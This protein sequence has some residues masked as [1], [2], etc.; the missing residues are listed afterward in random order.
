MT[1]VIGV[2]WATERKNRALVAL[3]I[4]KVGEWR[5]AHVQPAVEDETVVRACTDLGNAVVAVDTPFGWPRNFV[6]FVAGWRPT[7]ASAAPPEPDL[8]RL[9]R[10]DRV[11]RAEVP[12]EP[13]SVSAD[14]IAMGARCWAGILASQRLWAQV[15]LDGNRRG[16]GP[17]IVEVYPGAT[18]VALGRTRAVA[19]DEDSYK[20]DS[21][22]RRRVVRH[23]ASLL[24]VD[25]STHEDEIVSDGNDS[26]RTD[27]F[28]A[29]ITAGL[30]Q[31]CK[32]HG[33]A[34]RG[35]RVRHPTLSELEDAR[36][37]GWIFFPVADSAG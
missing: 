24:Q 13:L 11:V 16:D 5:V 23:V 35:W 1:R 37:E 12:K 2:D 18:L 22:T 26:D 21:A 36:T 33:A 10:T 29:A 32:N 28:L 20:K 7:E 25:L 27:A 6:E 34:W 4:N 3:D 9:R 17:A 30:Y 14:R 15:D 31:V 8:F 19:A